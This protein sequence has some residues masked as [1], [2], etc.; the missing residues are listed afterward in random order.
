MYFTLYNIFQCTMRSKVDSFLSAVRRSSSCQFRLITSTWVSSASQYLC[1]CFRLGVAYTLSWRH[2]VNCLFG[3]IHPTQCHGSLRLLCGLRMRRLRDRA[4]RSTALRL[5]VNSLPTARPSM[6]P[7]YH[8]TQ[9]PMERRI[10]RAPEYTNKSPKSLPL[11]SR[12]AK[13]PIS[14][15]ATPRKSISTAKTSTNLQC[16]SPLASCNMIIA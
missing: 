6:F 9:P 3:K 15:A 7:L 16:V 14:R 4:R 12:G 1:I 10:S 5:V 8:I 2:I 13:T 11:I